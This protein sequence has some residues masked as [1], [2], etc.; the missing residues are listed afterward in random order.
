MLRQAWRWVPEVYTQVLKTL[1]AWYPSSIRHASDLHAACISTL[2]AWA[3]TA[4][5]CCRALP[6]RHCS[7]G[8]TPQKEAVL[9]HH[10]SAGG[11]QA[12]LASSLLHSVKSAIWYAKL[13]SYII[14]VSRHVKELRYPTLQR[15]AHTL[16]KDL[17]WRAH[18]VRSI[19][20][21][22]R[23]RHWDFKSKLDAINRHS[24]SRSASGT[25]CPRK[26]FHLLYKGAWRSMFGPRPPFFK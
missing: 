20:V 10:R 24:E 4:S 12:T 22:E 1:F 23:N 19:R 16:P 5:G 21:L 18:V 6:R 15:V 25:Q 26:T 8:T 13:I 9:F 17:K 7:T 3:G 14:F 2:A 11:S